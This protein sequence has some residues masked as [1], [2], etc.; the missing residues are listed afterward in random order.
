MAVIKSSIGW[1]ERS[2]L[3]LR[4]DRYRIHIYLS[5]LITWIMCSRI[6][7][8]VCVSY[9]FKDISL[10]VCF[11]YFYISIYL[12]IN[13][14]FL[15]YIFIKCHIPEY[16]NHLFGTTYTYQTMH[17]ATHK[18]YLHIDYCNYLLQRECN[19]LNKDLG[20]VTMQWWILL[21]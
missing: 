17:V 20:G 13:I 14:Y 5:F 6:S 1:S 9:L 4:S 19:G 11:I 7:L 16:L 10:S 12:N 2:L 15:V 3:I 8:S 21:M 18:H